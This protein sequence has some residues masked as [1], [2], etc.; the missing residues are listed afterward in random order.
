[1]VSLSGSEERK[2]WTD[3]EANVEAHGDW[4]WSSWLRPSSYLLHRVKT[5]D[6]M[7]KSLF[8]AARIPFS[9]C[10]AYVD[11]LSLFHAPTALWF[12]IFY[13][14][15]FMYLFLLSSFWRSTQFLKTRLRSYL[16]YGCFLPCTSPVPPTSQLLAG[17]CCTPPP[18]HPAK[19]VYSFFY[20]INH[21]ILHTYW[22]G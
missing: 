18:R 8:P 10:G 4:K 2:E 16:L 1:M 5:P 6:M 20:K 11:L 9:C 17:F 21:K 7:H 13:S 12:W 3:V 15:W 19:Y 22:N 14:L